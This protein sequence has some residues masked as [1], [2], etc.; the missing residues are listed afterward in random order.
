VP[1]A[2]HQAAVGTAV[3]ERDLQGETKH[4]PAGTHKVYAWFL[5]TLP[6]VY[7]QEIHFVWYRDGNQVGRP[8]VSALS[9]GRKRGYR[10]WSSLTS[11]GVGHWRV[12]LLTDADQLIGRTSF[13]VDAPAS[14]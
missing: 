2:C 1:L 14:P 9:G 3:H 4:V 10:T 8:F 13:D 5:V 11:P 7:R 12:D 6:A